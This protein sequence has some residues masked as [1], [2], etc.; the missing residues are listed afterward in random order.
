LGGEDD[1]VQRLQQ[2]ARDVHRVV[3]HTVQQLVDAAG[4]D[5]S[6]RGVAGRDGLEQGAGLLAA[7]LADEDVLGA[8]S[9]GCDEEVEE[10]DGAGLAAATGVA[11]AV[12]RDAL[13]PVAVG[14]MDLG[15]VLDADHFA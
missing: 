1:E 12:A 14:E 11:E 13:N 2:G 6:H 7:H 4:V 10:S 8:L 9:E 3:L 5:G 15:G